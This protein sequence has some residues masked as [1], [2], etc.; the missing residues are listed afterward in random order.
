MLIRSINETHLEFTGNNEASGP[1][2]SP[3]DYVF[4]APSTGEYKLLMRLYQR[5]EGAE[6]DRSN[7]VYIRMAGNF[8]SATD[9]YITADLQTDMKFFGRGIDQW[10]GVYSGEGGQAN[11]KS[12]VLYNLI[13]GE[14]YT[15]TMSGRSQRANIDYILLYDTNDI[16]ITTGA[17]RDIAE[18]NDPQYRPDWDCNQ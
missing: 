16:S 8:T 11:N 18:L 15:F 6:S 7:D 5:L 1:A 13:E 3:L 2:T 9:K 10:G 4:T 14:E 12:A 17:N